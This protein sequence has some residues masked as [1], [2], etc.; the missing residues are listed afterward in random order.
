M[1]PVADRA[2]CLAYLIYLYRE[3][4]ADFIRREIDFTF[5][6]IGVVLATTG[7]R[8]GLLPVVPPGP[9][10]EAGAGIPR[11]RPPGLVSNLFNYLAPGTAGG[12]I[13]RAWGSRGARS[14][15]GPSPRPR[16]CS[17]G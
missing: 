7:D 13:V 6:G 2:G 10:P 11:G 4:Y 14:R 3:Q 17:T 9:G 1:A 12:D 16:C 8:A 5:L 15:G